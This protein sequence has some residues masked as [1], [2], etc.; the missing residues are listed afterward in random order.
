MKR[1][2]FGE[3]LAEA[4]AVFIIIAFGDS[5]AAMYT[6]YNPSPY[7]NS[8]WGVCIAWRSMPRDPSPARMP[9]RR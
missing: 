5:V 1:Q 4:L 7:L 2:D 8:Y 3:L 9:I 6:L